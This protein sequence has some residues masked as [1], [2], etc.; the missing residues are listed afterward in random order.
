MN[1]IFYSQLFD[2]EE[3][4]I[5]FMNNSFGKNRRK[6]HRSIVGQALSRHISLLFQIFT[7]V[8]SARKM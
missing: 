2:N 1:P 5:L 4:R 6:A 7:G 8:S 3:T